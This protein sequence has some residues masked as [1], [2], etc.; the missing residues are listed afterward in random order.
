MAANYKV[1]I[2]AAGILLAIAGGIWG[3]WGPIMALAAAGEV[4]WTRRLALVAA[5]GA[6]VG[7]AAVMRGR[8]PTGSGL[9]LL[10]G[11]VLLGTGSA[12]AGIVVVLGSTLVF[13]VG[14]QP[15]PGDV[16]EALRNAT[17]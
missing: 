2:A 11:V 7:A 10:C 15:V 13:G 4:F 14:E 8:V 6:I 12:G 16:R 1:L 9:A 3:A 17:P 5:I